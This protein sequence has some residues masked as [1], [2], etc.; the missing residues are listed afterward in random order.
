M[1]A[2]VLVYVRACVRACVCLT[3]HGKWL[4]SIRDITIIGVLYFGLIWSLN[5][6]T[7]THMYWVFHVLVPL[8]EWPRIAEL[9]VTERKAKKPNSK[10]HIADN[11][12]R[13]I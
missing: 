10:L 11:F 6:L 7:C 3:S 4:F 9:G 8:A 5:I 12:A 2:C 13:L 1:C